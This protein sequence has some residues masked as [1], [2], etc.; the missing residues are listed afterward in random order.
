MNEESNESPSRSAWNTEVFHARSISLTCSGGWQA[1]WPPNP[2]SW[3]PKEVDPF[4]WE[5]VA[6]AQA[7]SRQ[8]DT[9]HHREW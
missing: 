8:G 1:L 5:L 6:P 4:L 9:E 3:G 2:L 7:S